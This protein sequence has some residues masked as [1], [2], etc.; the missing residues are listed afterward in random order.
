MSPGFSKVSKPT[1]EVY[2]LDPPDGVCGKKGVVC[3]G[4]GGSSGGEALKGI[5]VDGREDLR[6]GRRSCD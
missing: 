2:P 4:R 6:A 3:A 5:G 1:F